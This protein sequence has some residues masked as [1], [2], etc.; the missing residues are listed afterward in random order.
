MINFHMSETFWSFEL[1]N[2][3]CTQA[4]A[5]V[6][7]CATLSRPRCVHRFL[8][9]ILNKNDVSLSAKSISEYRPLLLDLPLEI[10][11]LYT[12]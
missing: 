9:L 2:N 1:K 4:G 10:S 11:T 6:N 7:P 12:I 8:L 5:N 3:P